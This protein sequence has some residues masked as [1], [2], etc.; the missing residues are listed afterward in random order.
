MKIALDP[1]TYKLLKYRMKRGKYRSAD[2][3]VRTALTCLEQQEQIAD[4]EPGELDKLLRPALQEIERGELLDGKAVFEE[5]RKLS[6]S[7]N[8]R[9]ARNTPRAR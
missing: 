7:S 1:K 4:F 2:E 6:R 9:T 3:V 8:D 5:I